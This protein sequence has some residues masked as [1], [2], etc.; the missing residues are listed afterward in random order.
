MITTLNG[1]VAAPAP[2]PL[3]SVEHATCPVLDKIRDVAERIAVREEIPS[4]CT[5][6][7]VVEPRTENEISSNTQEGAI[8][9]SAIMQAQ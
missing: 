1:A 6:A 8:E 2:S 3:Y 7:A 9:E 4:T 5:I